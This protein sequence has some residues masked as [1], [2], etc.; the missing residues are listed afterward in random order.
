ME[1]LRAQPNIL[2]PVHRAVKR[3]FGALPPPV[4]CSDRSAGRA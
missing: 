1:K 3:P 2:N 4:S